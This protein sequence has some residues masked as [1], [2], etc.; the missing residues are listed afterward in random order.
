MRREQA[1]QRRAYRARLELRPDEAAIFDQLPEST[2]TAIAHYSA[3]NPDLI[4]RY[5]DDPGETAGRTS[6]A[7]PGRVTINRAAKEPLEQV[8]AHE[9]GHTIADGGAGPAIERALL[10]DAEAGTPDDSLQR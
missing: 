8:F 5:I 9:A 3:A 6:S 1:A 2:Q 7:E 4:V 10:G